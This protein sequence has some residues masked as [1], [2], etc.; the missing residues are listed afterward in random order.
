MGLLAKREPRYQSMEAGPRRAARLVTGFSH[1]SDSPESSDMVS[2]GRQLAERSS[3]VTD[4][5]LGIRDNK[6]T[7]PKPPLLG[8]D[9][10][11]AVIV[12]PNTPPFDRG[13]FDRRKRRMAA[14]IPSE[15][16][17]ETSRVKQEWFGLIFLPVVSFAAQ[18]LVAI[19]YFMEKLSFM[20][21]EPPR[22]LRRRTIDLSIQFTL[23]WMPFIVLLRGG[24]TSLSSSFLATAAWFYDG[25][26]SLDK[27]SFC[28]TVSSVLAIHPNGTTAT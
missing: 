10:P 8:C 19:I 28:E 23:F 6:K 24:T 16:V 11:A 25:Q 21:A 17:R 9:T 18:A 26:Q 3:S 13:S 14:R 15:H 22:C 12:H 2:L 1:P 7:K 4:A 5:S 20:D 27:M